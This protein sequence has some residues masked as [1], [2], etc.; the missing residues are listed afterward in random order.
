[1]TD[2]EHIKSL[3]RE[4][5]LYRKQSLLEESKEKYEEILTFL[6][7]HK[8]YS[9]DKKLIDA[10]Q[11]KIRTVEGLLDEIES[12]PEMP[13]LSQ[14]IHELIR[15]IF[16]FS[17]NED[18]A[19]M[20][21]AIALAKLGQYDEAIK[22]FQGLIQE[23][24]IPLVAA[25]NALMCHL[26]LASADAAV[27]QF[28]QWLSQETFSL[29]ELRY[30]RSILRDTLAK[31][32]IQV[33]LPQVS[34]QSPAEE[35]EQ[36]NEEGIIDISS[37]AVQL[38]NGPRKGQRTEFEVSF[39]SGNTISTVIEAKQQDVVD[40]FRLGLQLPDIECFSSLA[41]F[42]GR[43]VVS[44]MKKISSGRRKGDYSLDISIEVG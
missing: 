36:K 44:G 3:I 16:S 7:G 8:Q 6:Q 27:A 34:G 41:V 43:G 20:E 25:K 21:G 11:G 22:A 39:Q 4:A 17:E 30:L 13:E 5:E 24:I 32:G 10:V 9:K 2:K 31:R 26:H 23:G 12:A 29:K 37:F 1:M 40:A 14:E 18:T 28:T 33:D 35:S 19:A 38:A 15:R 42:K